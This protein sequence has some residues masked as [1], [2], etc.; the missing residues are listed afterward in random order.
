MT[1]PPSDWTVRAG[2]GKP[3]Y[4]VVSFHETLVELRAA[5]TR[6]TGWSQ[7][8]QVACV[9]RCFSP[10][11]PGLLG[12]LFI[13][14]E[15]YTSAIAVHEL[16]HA[17]FRVMESRQQKVRHWRADRRARWRLRLGLS[18]NNGE[19]SKPQDHEEDYALVLEHMVEGFLMEAKL[20]G[21]A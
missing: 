16:S 21:L 7:P 6:Y 18:L 12:V 3:E 9:V 19:I 14:R 4:F 17:A 10:Q 11:L 5:M 8:D 2:W 20:H 1:L 13:A 15:D